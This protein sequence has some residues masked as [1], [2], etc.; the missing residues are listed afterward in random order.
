[1]LFSRLRDISRALSL[2]LTLFICEFFHLCMPENSLGTDPCLIH[3]CTSR[4][5]HGAWDTKVL[6]K[7]FLNR[8]DL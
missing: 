2:A 4:M 5:Q 3:P 1:M 7:Y 6:Y 8:I